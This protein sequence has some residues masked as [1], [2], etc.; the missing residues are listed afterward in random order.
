M[1]QT[2]KQTWISTI[3]AD[4]LAGLIVTLDTVVIKSRQTGSALVDRFGVHDKP[5]AI[6]ALMGH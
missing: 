4:R 6:H 1:L 3:R 5:D 2:L